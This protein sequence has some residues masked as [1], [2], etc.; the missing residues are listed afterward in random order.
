MLCGWEGNRRSGVAL[1]MR[2]RLHWFIHLRPRQGDE[3]PAYALLWSVVHLPYVPV[4]RAVTAGNW[5]CSAGVELTLRELRG[6]LLCVCVCVC[7]VSRLAV[8]EEFKVGREELLDR[9]TS[10]EDEIAQREQINRAQLDLQDRQQVDAR[11]KCVQCRRAE[12]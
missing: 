2:H 10:L 12:L 7:E 8:I 11:N 4:I 5:C 9:I 6:A 1:A 3:H